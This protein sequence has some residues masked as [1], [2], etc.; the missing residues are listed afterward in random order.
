MSVL[1]VEP[2]IMF[3]LFKRNVC[4][5]S[6]IAGSNMRPIMAVRAILVSAVTVSVVGWFLGLPFYATLIAV[7]CGVMSGLMTAALYKTPA[8]PLPSRRPGKHN[9]EADS[10]RSML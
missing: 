9:V 10:W 3:L 6:I 4:A 8:P 1:N 5:K 7:G 2:H